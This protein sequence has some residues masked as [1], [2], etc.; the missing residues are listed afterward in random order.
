MYFK[1]SIIITDPCYVVKKSSIPKEFKKPDDKD[2]FSFRSK[3]DYPDFVVPDCNVK[4]QLEEFGLLSLLSSFGDSKMYNFE[5]GKYEQALNEYEVQ[6][7]EY[8]HWK[9]CNYGYNMENLGFKTFLTSRTSGGDWSC[10]TY[11][12]S[13]NRI[14]KSKKIGEFCADTGMVGVFLFDEVLEYNP[15]FDLPISKPWTTTFINDFDGD[16]EI[17]KITKSEDKRKWLYYDRKEQVRIYGKGNINF[18]T[19]QIIK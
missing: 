9:K 10:N 15:N 18:Y 11:E 4:G 5:Y 14:R 16:I 8:D 2:Y 1:G 6:S 13:K 12:W 19:A 3:E 7:K 17:K